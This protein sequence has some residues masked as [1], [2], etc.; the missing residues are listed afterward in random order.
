MNTPPPIQ[1]PDHNVMIGTPAY[2]GLMHS[3]YVQSVLNFQAFNI[4]YMLLTI[5]N[6]SLI[7]RAR[8][9]IMAAFAVR[10]ECTHLLFLDSDVSLPAQGLQRMIA[11]GR[12]VI[13]APVA[14]KGK[15]PDGTR[16]FNYG[17]PLGEDGPYYLVEHVGTAALMFSRRAADA[18]VAEARRDGRVY[19]RGVHVRGEKMRAT[20]HY[21]VFRTGVVGNE[22]LSEDYW[23][24]RQLRLMGFN[25]H[26][27]PGIVT[28]HSGMIET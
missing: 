14:L 27:D 16:N 5:G 7:T 18:L 25:I 10:T 24:C 9:T 26:V 20:E 17:Q 19:T 13:A 6:E 8:N 21:D 12:D 4:K 3:D 2:H 15:N 11:S 28:R 23:A 22:Y 1:M